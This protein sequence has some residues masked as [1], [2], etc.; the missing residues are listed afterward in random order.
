V[1]TNTPRNPGPLAGL[2][3]LLAS[4]PRDAALR[5]G[6]QEGFRGVDP[7][8]K[9]MP[10]GETNVLAAL[11]RE[12]GLGEKKE[13]NDFEGLG[14]LLEADDE[15]VFT[16]VNDLVLRQELLAK[17]RLALDKHWSAVKAGYT[18]SELTKV[19]NQDIWRQ[20]FPPGSE[21]LR[22]TATP[23]K[24]ADL[25]NK[26]VETLLNDPPKPNVEPDVD[27]EVAK[28]GAAMAEQFLLQDS[29]ETGTN[30]DT[31]FRA[32]TER[33]T[34][35]ASAFL[36]YWMDKRGGGSLPLQIKA[37]P[38]ATDVN[39]PLDAQGP[40][41]QPIPTTD[42][43]LRYVTDDNQFTNDPAAA[44]RVWT[45]KQRI[46]KWGREHIRMF[47]EDKDLGECQCVVGLFYCTL[48]EARRRWPVV[49]QMNDAER[50]S[51]CDWTPTRYLVLLP[52]ALRARWKITTGSAKDPK[53]SSNDERILF[54]YA[55][56]RRQEYD[57][58]KGAAMFVSGMDNGLVLERD[59]LSAEVKVPAKDKQDTEV[60]DT[61]DMEIPVVQIRLLQD[62]E[63]R[64]PMGKAFIARVAGAGEAGTTLV[65][66]LL[67]AIDIT[68]HPARFTTS[69]SPLTASDIE[70]SRALGDFATVLTS[71]DYPKYEEPPALPPNF[72]QMIQWQYE[73]MDN[74]AGLNK[75]LQGADSQQEVSGIARRIAVGQSMV[76]L[77]PMQ[78]AIILAYERH[79]RIKL[80][81]AMRYLTTPQ[82]L[83]YVG[84][85]GAYKEEWFTGND[86]SRAGRISVKTGT[87]TM[88]APQ[89]KVQYL[90]TLQQMNFL[91]AEEAAEAARPAYASVLGI[92]DNPHQQRIERQVSSWLEGPPEGW[93]ERFRQYQ[94]ELAAYQQYQQQLQQQQQQQMQEQQRQQ[95]QQQQEMAAAPQRQQMQQK[96]Q[97]HEMQMRS[98]QEAHAQKL[99]QQ[100]DSHQMQMRL[101]AE[102]AEA[103]PEGGE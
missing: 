83:S 60:T 82:M 33:A 29:R 48:G 7:M 35:S 75:P 47:P 65:T 62:A 27:T 31:L 39:H 67:E 79:W 17:N 66:S 46:E 96:G 18:W 38:E 85:D 25:C 16:A 4:Q 30:D 3:A 45:P 52:P 91:D 102:K 43:I 72:L 37:H 6:Q 50:G 55:Y 69:T 21:D 36:H 99:S 26:L 98:A 78:Q 84:P 74:S 15:T 22:T 1:A 14:E 97:Q 64:D 77:S 57:Y 12:D 73:Q 103:R 92:G 63:D 86:F 59:V 93:V 89:E 51:L 101:A 13:E 19:E 20:E 9:E 76:A 56:Y 58:P 44:K 42:Y 94:Q 2:D 88:M 71:Q 90:A 8:L 68:L 5:G 95:V 54:Y 23:N 61:R 49:E 11:D 32:Q 53:G 80:E 41:G 34:T 24:A 70:Q 81:M 87:G 10:T 40:D 28:A 100:Q